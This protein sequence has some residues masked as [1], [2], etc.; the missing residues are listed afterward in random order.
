MLRWGM[1]PLFWAFFFKAVFLGLIAI[2]RAA[3]EK[4][5]S[6][7]GTAKPSIPAQKVAKRVEPR[8]LTRSYHRT[9]NVADA[10]RISRHP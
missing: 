6:A 2:G 4:K 8:R 10:R 1:H 5:W 9:D 7:G 3:F